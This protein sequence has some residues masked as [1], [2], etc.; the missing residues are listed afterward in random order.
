[1]DLLLTALLA[2]GVVLYVG[3][4]AAGALLIALSSLAGLAGALPLLEEL[5]SRLSRAGR[6]R[7]VL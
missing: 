3:L 7:A 4:A 6:T 2:T 5:A 1:M